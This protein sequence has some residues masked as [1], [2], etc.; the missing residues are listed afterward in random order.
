M[1]IGIPQTIKLSAAEIQMRN[2]HL[3]KKKIIDHGPVIIK[4]IFQCLLFNNFD[5][6]VS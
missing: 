5:I 6:S 4:S 1:K 2:V 3:K